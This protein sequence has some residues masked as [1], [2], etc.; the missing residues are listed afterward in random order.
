MFQKICKYF[1]VILFALFFLFLSITTFHSEFRR[2][3]LNYFI[4]SINLYQVIDM[5]NVVKKKDIDFNKGAEKI[6]FFIEAQ[7]KYSNGRS[8]FLI[9]TYDAL[10][11]L[12]SKATTKENYIALEKSFKKILEVDPK[13][14]EARN[15]LAKSYYYKKNYKK[16]LKEI[17]QSIEIAPLQTEGYRIAFKIA[18]DTK[19]KNI[20][21]DYCKKY[22]DSN[23]GGAQKRFKT[24]YFGG[25]TNNS[26]GILAK[27]K[28][29]VTSE[30]YPFTGLLFNEINK[31]EL[32]LPNPSS[33]KELDIYLSFT[34]G[35]KLQ[36]DSIILIDGESNEI[37]INQEDIN[38]FSKSSFIL[39]D[40]SATEIILVSEE[41]E[42]L[43]LALSKEYQNITQ[44]LLNLKFKK[45]NLTNL[46]CN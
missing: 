39:N 8:R 22:L 18:H 34:A 45:F 43:N 24:T 42:I 26:L 25:M 36:V 16:S 19:D 5:Q 4:A 12:E 21:D 27:D 44:I 6:V 37:E 28:D 3:L 33:V 15:W 46:N 11:I 13:I 20:L 14:Y 38:V 9:G 31:F 23:F 10:K 7:K 41:D 1:F 32:S 35:V 29:N 30:I 17:A 2:T 40:N